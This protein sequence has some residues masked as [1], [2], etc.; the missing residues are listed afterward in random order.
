MTS[1]HISVLDEPKLQFGHGQNHC[2]PKDGLFLFGPLVDERKPDVMRVGVVGTPEGLAKYR[3]WVI[4]ANGYLPPLA[5]DVPHHTAFPGF[6]AA[7]HTRWPTIPI[8]ELPI[9]GSE[10]SRAI[11]ISDRHLAIYE[12]VSLFSSAIE[13]KLREDDVE[14]DVWF[15]VVPEEVYHLGRPLSRVRREDRIDIGG[16]ISAR[17]GQRLLR[18]PSMF[19]EEMEQAEVY[20]YEIN[21]HHQ[22]KARLLS[23]KA[24]VQIVRET[25]LDPQEHVVGT[26]SRRLQDPAT[27]NWNLCTTAYFKAGGRPWKLSRLREG[28]CYVGLVFKKS[29]TDLAMGNA[30]CGAQMFLDSGDGLVFKGA[31]GPWYSSDLREFHLPEAE[32]KS[33]IDLVIHS[34]RASHGT[35]PKELFIHGRTRFNDAEWTG[36]ASATPNGTHLVGVRISRSQDLKLFR[37]N[38][39]PVLRGTTCYLSRTR[40]LIWTMGFIPEINTY[41]GREVPNPLSV[42]VC[43]GEADLNVVLDDIM[44]LTKVNFNACIYADG[45]PVTLRFADAV[46]EILTAGPNTDGPPLP[47]RHYI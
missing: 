31:V 2:N 28:V 33:L 41:P 15:V 21:F 27:L 11:R 46:G 10:I 22:L 3:R 29:P 4:R 18:E 25:S 32:A 44:G 35:D 5:F 8:T 26:R 40:A 38:K 30:C 47:F 20:R 36:F 45:L 24:V 17:Q 37:P 9:S 19:V 39:T 23:V 6:E 12:T 34:Y 43:R 7:F 13:T 14:V 1:P 16:R 42:E